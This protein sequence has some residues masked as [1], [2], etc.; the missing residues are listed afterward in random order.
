MMKF[1]KKRPVLNRLT[2]DNEERMVKR[3]QRK[4][5]KIKG[6]GSI[7]VGVKIEG[8]FACTLRFVF[9]REQKDA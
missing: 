6:F 5:V 2:G 3:R 4:A 9:V 7:L 8:D 1:E